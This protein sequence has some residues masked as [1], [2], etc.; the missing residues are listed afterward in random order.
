ME[1]QEKQAVKQTPADL[2]LMVPKNSKTGVRITFLS[3]KKIKS[4]FFG[5]APT[6]EIL[7]AHFQAEHVRME[8]ADAEA[9]KAGKNAKYLPQ[10]LYLQI[11]SS[12]FAT[13]VEEARGK[14]KD[15][16]G[17]ALC[18]TLGSKIPC[19][20]ITPM[21]EAPVEDE[22]PKQVRKKRTPKIVIN[23]D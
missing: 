17:K 14:D 15:V 11:Q 12:I 23:N 3:V 2:Y 1:E 22:Q 18:L 20:V 5:I 10:P 16:D 7:E 8:I 19:C 21:P 9:K 6:R 4:F 13:I